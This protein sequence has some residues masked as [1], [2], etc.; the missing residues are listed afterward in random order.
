MVNGEWEGLYVSLSQRNIS[1]M[2]PN[3]KQE[4]VEEVILDG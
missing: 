2:I 3:D 1:H 4:P